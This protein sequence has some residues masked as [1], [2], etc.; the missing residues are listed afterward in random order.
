V[1]TDKLLREFLSISQAERQRLGRTIHDGISQLLAALSM[2][3]HSLRDAEPQNVEASLEECRSLVAQA[4]E[5]VRELSL[6]LSPMILA[7]GTLPD[8][9]RSYLNHQAQRTGLNI[10]VNLA[11]SWKPVPREIEIACLRVIQEAV[12]NVSRHAAARWL[13]VSLA[14]DAENIEFSVRDDGVGFSPETYRSWSPASKRLGLFVMRQQIESL[15][16]SWQIVSA[17]G[18]GTSIQVRL[19]VA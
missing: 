14:Q 6:T 3:L 12:S 19:P 13:H 7:Y 2:H 5:Q 16:G 15:N 17:P 1:S 9:V 4:I 11:T 10:N 8:E 18:Q